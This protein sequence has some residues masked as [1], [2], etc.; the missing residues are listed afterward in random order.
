[1]NKLDRE[2]RSRILHLL[3]SSADDDPL[4]LAARMMPHHAAFAGVSVGV[5]VTEAVSGAV[6]VG[7]VAVAV[8]VEDPFSPC[9]AM[10]LI[11]SSLSFEPFD[12]PK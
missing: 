2:A 7:A 5:K 1:M 8:A 6:A 11:V 3:F 4:R 12:E 10:V 9:L